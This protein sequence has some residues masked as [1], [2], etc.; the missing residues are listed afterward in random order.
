MKREEGPEVFRGHLEECFGHLGRSI[1]SQAPRGARG[2]AQ[3]KKPVADFCGVTTA[4]VT[5]W[6]YG[7]RGL[8]AGEVL[9]KLMC[10]LDLV[11]YRV[12][13]LERMPKVRRNFAELI[14]F[15]LLSGKEAAAL[16]GYATTSILYKALKGARGTS[17]AKEQ[18][19]LEMWK[20]K[21]EGLEQCREQAQKQY[22]PDASPPTR[23]PADKRPAATERGAKAPA[24]RKTAAVSIMK[25]LLDLLEE[26][27]VDELSASELVS[28]RSDADTILR[29]SAHLSALSSRLFM[30][31]QEKG[32]D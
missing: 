4:S 10:Y 23:P 7:S 26:K 12:I 1:A 6:M 24:H 3:A 25:G 21:K 22:L 11:G 29:L 14:G 32:D 15:S 28:F 17:D 18:K 5:R 30:S 27:P 31:E 20:E 8:P 2:A 9:I 16:L 13:E 19:M